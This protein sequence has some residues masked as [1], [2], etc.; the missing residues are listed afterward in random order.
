MAATGSRS[1]SRRSDIDAGG[2]DK[3]RRRTPGKAVAGRPVTPAKGK[4]FDVSGDVPS[5]LAELLALG[6][7]GWVVSCYQKLEPGDRANDKFRIKLK[8]R[9]RV[10]H[11]RLGIL[12][13]SHDERETIGETLDQVESFFRNNTNLSGARGI[14]VFAG[15]GWMRAV[16]LPHVLRSRVLV[17]RTPVVGELVAYTEHGS[18]VLAVVADR[19]SAR[20]FAVDLEGAEEIEGVVNPEATRSSK[21]HGSDDAPGQGEYKFHNKIREE[22][23]RHLARISDEVAR[24]FRQR[25]FDGVVVGGVGPDADALLPHLPSNVRDR[26]LGVVKLA[27]K[28][29]T[30]AE[31]RE[32]AIALWADATEHAAADAVGELEGLRAS[33]WAV[34]GVDATLKAL[35]RGQVRTLLVDQE[36]VVPGYRMAAS[37][38]LTLTPSGLRSEGEPLPIADLLDD[39]IEDALRQR[40]RVYALMGDLAGE[41]DKIA[42]ILRFRTAK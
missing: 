38:R 40:A 35:S 41:F 4:A 17:D 1:S 24:A 39:A 30:P 19:V 6:D 3:Q 34:D 33:G 15:Q 16:R 31:V 14:A 11:E 32:R 29:V 26:V 18:R 13:F 20:L 22:K 42:A 23:H 25:A 7:L 2:R 21:Y 37:G 8:N 28:H 5:T 27:P 36:A 10:A 9:L 12:G